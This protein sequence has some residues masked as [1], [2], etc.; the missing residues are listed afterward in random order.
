MLRGRPAADA[1]SGCEVVS[2][3]RER[4]IGPTTP[5]DAAQPFQRS[6]VLYCQRSVAIRTSNGRRDAE[7]RPQSACARL[8]QE[9]PART[10][11]RGKT[12]DAQRAIP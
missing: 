2:L 6:T 11:L 7:R 5:L 1:R 10:P 3:V 4:K 12:A 8:A 9:P